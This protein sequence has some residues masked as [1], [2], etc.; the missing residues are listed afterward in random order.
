LP[1]V[2]VKNTAK[3]FFAMCCYKEHGKDDICRMSLSMARQSKSGKYSRAR[4]NR[5]VDVAFIL[6]RVFS[7]VKTAKI[8]RRNGSVT[9]GPAATYLLSLPCVFASPCS[10]WFVCHV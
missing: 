8:F 6:C 5:S 2:A 7:G 1:C 10:T 3:M 9:R 4:E